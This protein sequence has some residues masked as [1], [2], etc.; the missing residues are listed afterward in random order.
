VKFTWVHFE[1]KMMHFQRF[2][3]F[4]WWRDWKFS[5]DLFGLLFCHNPSLQCC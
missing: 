2:W 1:Y 4:L 3:H 5:C